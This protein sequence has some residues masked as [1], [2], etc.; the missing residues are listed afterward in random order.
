MSIPI[1]ELAG[2]E[3]LPGQVLSEATRSWEGQVA[4]SR[5]PAGGKMG[6]NLLFIGVCY[7]APFLDSSW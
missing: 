4:E 7:V 3:G 5:W 2:W 6:G 1:P